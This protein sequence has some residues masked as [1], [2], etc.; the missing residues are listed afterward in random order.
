MR[1]S[2]KIGHGEFFRL[3]GIL[4]L[5]DVISTVVITNFF[6]GHNLIIVKYVVLGSLLYGYLYMGRLIVINS[7]DWKRL[8]KEMAYN[9]FLDRV[10]HIL[11]S[12]LEFQ[13]VF[14]KF[15]EELKSEI[16]F[17]IAMIYRV[18]ES[19]GQI[20]PYMYADGEQVMVLSQHFE[21]IEESFLKKIIQFRQPILIT[22]PEQ[23]MRVDRLADH[24]I[25]SL[26]LV[27]MVYQSQIQGFLFLA[28]KER[29]S[30]HSINLNIL[31]PVAE[32]LMISMANCILYEKMKELSLK[33]YLTQ[34]PNRRALDLQLDYEYRRAKRY[35]EPFSILVLDID[36]FKKLNDL[37]GHLAGD[38]TLQELADLMRAEVR[39]IDMVS[40]FGGE[41]FVILLPETNEE[42]AT[43]V[44]ERIRKRVAENIF[45]Q[46]KEKVKMTVSVGVASYIEGMDGIQ[47]LLKGADF[48]LY[49]AKESGRN[50]VVFLAQ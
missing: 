17:D 1:V 28:S 8:H 25:Q 45:L 6:E 9:S 37:Y 14:E 47:E 24:Q 41:E 12:D 20:A 30:Y 49:S 36:H 11:V 7:E 18:E 48:K 23:I 43:V 3:F 31:Q 33:D 40:R 4:L 39:D 34:C 46:E 50:Q 13:Q 21:R 29:K 35:Q 19:F 38:K 10:N 2:N 27:P 42:Q 26:V 44:A 22:D 32:R 5:I 15:L 16:P